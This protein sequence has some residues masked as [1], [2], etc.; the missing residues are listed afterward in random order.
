MNKFKLDTKY[1][2][3][4]YREEIL[5]KKKLTRAPIHGHRQYDGKHLSL[6]VHTKGDD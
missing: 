4:Y 1:W 6:Y 3:Y 5:L 2:C